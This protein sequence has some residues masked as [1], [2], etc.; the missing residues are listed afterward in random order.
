MI[1]VIATIH[2]KQGGRA[3][4][5]KAFKDN[6]ENVRAERGCV[7]YFPAV[8]IDAEIPAQVLDP[9]TVTVIEKWQSVE[10][11]HEHLKAPHMLAYREQV[12]DI[13]ERIEIKVLREA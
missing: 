7:E 3:T 2:V 4:F 1:S 12:A 6:L 13:V 9:Q 5:L 8:D 11:L 10:A